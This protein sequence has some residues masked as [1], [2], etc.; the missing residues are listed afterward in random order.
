MIIL[1]GIKPTGVPHLGNYFG[2]IAPALA[3]QNQHRCLFFIADYHALVNQPSA[4]Q[5]ARHS[6]EV[7]A[8]WLACGLDPEHSLL[9][10]Q[11]DIPEIF[12]LQWILTCFTAKGVLN[13]SH[14]YKAKLDQNPPEHPDDGITMGLFNYPV[15][16]AADILISQAT[17][18]PVGV[19]QQ[20]HVEITRDLALKFHH[21][22]GQDVFTI[23]E[24][25]LTPH[26]RPVPGLDNRK[27]SKSYNNH[28]PLFLPMQ[29]LQK[30]IAKI[31]TD[32]STPTA[33]KPTTGVIYE[34]HKALTSPEELAGLDDKLAQGCGWG[35]LK[36]QLARKITHH[37][38]EATERYHTYMNRPAEIEDILAQGAAQFRPAARKLLAQVKAVI[39]FST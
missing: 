33:P 24:L 10:R 29:Q 32:S 35:E 39:G 23:P 6:V 14:A 36:E 17:C 12:E 8:T 22:Y 15:L 11:S 7:A 4:E 26:R 34:L 25:K 1:T 19:D 31:P 2:A 18:I 38:A 9:Y 5:L 30:L 21:H 28:I 27:M 37:F 13:R 3:Y 20:Q 16:M